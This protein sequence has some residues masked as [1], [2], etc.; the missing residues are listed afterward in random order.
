MWLYVSFN[1]PVLNACKCLMQ[2][3]DE[4]CGR[5]PSAGRE[6]WGALFGVEVDTEEN[7]FDGFSRDEM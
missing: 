7:D 3:C 4:V 2:A 5:V 6:M 1:V